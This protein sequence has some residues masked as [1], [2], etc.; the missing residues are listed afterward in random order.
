MGS[1]AIASAFTWRSTPRHHSLLE[2]LQLLQLQLQEAAL[3]RR[4][5]SRLPAAES[6][7]CHMLHPCPARSTLCWLAMASLLLAGDR[8]RLEARKEQPLPAL[9]DL[10]PRLPAQDLQQRLRLQQQ[11]HR[12]GRRQGHRQGR[13]QGCRL[14]ARTLASRCPRSPHFRCRRRSRPGRLLTPRSGTGLMQLLQLLLLPLLRQAL[15]FRH[16]GLG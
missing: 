12:Q 13:R 3:M 1:S 16:C 11:H 10:Q 9:L 2:P 6:R 15:H 5:P 14:A 7:R 4:V 8:S